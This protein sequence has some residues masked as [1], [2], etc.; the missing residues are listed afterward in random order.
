M[1]IN[2]TCRHIGITDAIKNYV[3][4]K[5]SG[6]VESMPNVES[7]HVILDIQKI[8]QIVEVVIQGKNHLRVEAEAESE[9]MYKS[10]DIVVDKVDR[11][12]KKFR[13]K[14]VD[15]KA[16]SRRA[17]ITDLEQRILKETGI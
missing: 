10:I 11:Q 5:L 13:K 7:V 14:I 1:N 17:K 9:D 2:I 12:L 3:D 16:P 15:H 8:R 6:V 4:E